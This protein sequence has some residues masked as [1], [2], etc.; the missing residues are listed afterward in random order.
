M[1]KLSKVSQVGHLV[2]LADPVVA[3]PDPG[4]GN[5]HRFQDHSKTFWVEF[6]GAVHASQDVGEPMIQ[7]CQVHNREPGNDAARFLK[8]ADWATFLTNWPVARLGNAQGGKTPTHPAHRRDKD[9]NV[10]AEG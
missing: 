7:S 10:V 4:A 5:K 3:N 1:G 6:W 2:A 9:A 8:A